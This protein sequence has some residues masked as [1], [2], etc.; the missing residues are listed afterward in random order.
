MNLTQAVFKAMKVQLPSVSAKLLD[1]MTK[2]ASVA[3]DTNTEVVKMF[4]QSNQ[5][6]FSVKH[7]LLVAEGLD[8]SF[9][10]RSKNK[11]EIQNMLLQQFRRDE[12]TSALV[13]LDEL[14]SDWIQ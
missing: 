10:S 2:L 14:C 5:S 8:T 13:I 11:D 7:L 12:H 1:V 9:M 4:V 6:M 3:G